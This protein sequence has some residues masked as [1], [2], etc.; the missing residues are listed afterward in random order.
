MEGSCESDRGWN[1]VYP[2]TFGDEGKTG[3]KLDDNDLSYAKAMF[4]RS[5]FKHFHDASQLSLL[6]ILN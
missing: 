4:Q 6:Q 1:E 3:L 5:I 2:A